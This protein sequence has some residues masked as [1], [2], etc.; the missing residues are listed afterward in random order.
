M[1]EAVAVAVGLRR[2]GWAWPDIYPVAIRGFSN[3][4]FYQRS[5]R[6]FNLRG[7]VRAYRRRRKKRK[8][9]S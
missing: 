5:Y 3:M 1:T 7:A 6:M 9:G 8:T 2:K 4:E